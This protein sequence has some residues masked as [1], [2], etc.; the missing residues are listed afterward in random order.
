MKRAHCDGD[1]DEMT[2]S[3]E[4]EEAVISSILNAAAAAAKDLSSKP[5]EKRGSKKGK[6]KSKNDCLNSEFSRMLR[7]NHEVML[8]V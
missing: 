8:Q 2:D 5:V 7:V 3:D 4:E 1:S 6:P